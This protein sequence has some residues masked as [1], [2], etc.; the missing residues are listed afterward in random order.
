MTPHELLPGAISFAGWVAGYL[1]NRYGRP[2]GVWIGSRIRRR[3]L[4]LPT[5]AIRI[6]PALTPAEVL[7][8]EPQCTYP[9]AGWWCSFEAD[10]DGPCAARPIPKRPLT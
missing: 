7:G 6:P 3:R 1:S 2:L 10:H 9:P 8:F 5:V 4:R